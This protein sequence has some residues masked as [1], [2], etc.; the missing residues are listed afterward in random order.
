MIPQHTFTICFNKLNSD[1][2]TQPDSAL[3]SYQIWFKN[4]D[5]SKDPYRVIAV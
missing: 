2:L 1:Q 5:D 3:N 4:Y